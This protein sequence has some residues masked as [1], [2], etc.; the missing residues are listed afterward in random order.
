M[1]LLVAACHGAGAWAASLPHCG[2]PPRLP[3]ALPLEPSSRRAS[4]AA[5]RLRGHGTCSARQRPPLCAAAS[6]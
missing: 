2:P 3:P 4:P 5:A 1:R 6:S